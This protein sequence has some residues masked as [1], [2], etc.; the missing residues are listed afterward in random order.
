MS[1][2]ITSFNALF[3]FVLIIIKRNC[4]S[5]WVDEWLKDKQVHRGALLLKTKIGNPDMCAAIFKLFGYMKF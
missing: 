1:D 4:H 2:T 3:K 5:D